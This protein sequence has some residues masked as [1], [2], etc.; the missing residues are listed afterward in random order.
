MELQVRCYLYALY[1]GP[2]SHA[3]TDNCLSKVV[4]AVWLSYRKNGVRGGAPVPVRPTCRY[5]SLI[6]PFRCLVG[7]QASA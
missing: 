4:K 2:V 7:Q 6:V 3:C 1:I 5:Q